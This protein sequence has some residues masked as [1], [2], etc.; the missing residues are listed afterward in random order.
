V[1]VT[2]PELDR[3]LADWDLSLQYVLGMVDKMSV[4]HVS[5]HLN[6]PIPEVDSVDGLAEAKN[7]FVLA[8]ERADNL[9][10]VEGHELEPDTL[11]EGVPPS[12]PD[13]DIWAGIEIPV[14]SQVAMLADTEH[15]ADGR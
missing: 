2:I 8:G 3:K 15:V 12:K 6:T 13:L 10:V 14:E 9:V 5:G 11:G 4:K 7:G 1:L